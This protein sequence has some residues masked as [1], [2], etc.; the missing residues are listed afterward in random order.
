VANPVWIGDA[1]LF[2]DR[3]GDVAVPALL[4][5]TRGN[6]VAANMYVP[7]IFLTSSTLSD[8]YDVSTCPAA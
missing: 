3:Y 2:P 7:S 6:S 8:F 4:D 5:A 1:A